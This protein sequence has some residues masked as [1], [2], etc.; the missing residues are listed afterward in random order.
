MGPISTHLFHTC[1]GVTWVGKPP[2]KMPGEVFLHRPE[3]LTAHFLSLS[4]CLTCAHTHTHTHTHTHYSGP[5]MLQNIHTCSGGDS[6]KSL[7]TPEIWRKS[8]FQSPYCWCLGKVTRR[9]PMWPSAKHI[10][11]GFLY[12][13]SHKGSPRI[14]EWVAYPFSRKSS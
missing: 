11:S 4:V 1:Q 9:L 12:Q 5:R 13:L 6:G 3:G 7:Q 8:T 2:P 14:V 10:S